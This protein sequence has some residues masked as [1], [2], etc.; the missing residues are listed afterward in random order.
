MVA[1]W[2]VDRFNDPCHMVVTLLCNLPPS[3]ILFLS[4]LLSLLTLM[5]KTTILKQSTWQRIYGRLQPTTSKELSSLSPSTHKQ[6]NPGNI[7]SWVGLEAEF[8]P[9][10]SEISMD[11]AEIPG[12][13]WETLKQKIQVSQVWIPNP[14]K[15]WNNKYVLLTSLRFVVIC[16]AAVNR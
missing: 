11:L 10:K 14:Q 1:G 7:Q 5:K 3:L 15:L 2:V 6:W 12:L 16:Y 8:A 13:L 4:C 9:F